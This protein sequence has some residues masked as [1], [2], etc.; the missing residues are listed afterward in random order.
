MMSWKLHNI[1]V[2][3]SFF[4]VREKKKT[5]TLQPH[6]S[7]IKIMKLAGLPVS[8]NTTFE[9]YV[10]KATKPSLSTARACIMLMNGE[11]CQIT[12]FDKQYNPS[13]T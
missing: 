2:S 4:Q 9:L 11:P 8:S 13:V 6:K 3:L 12:W 7:L 10:D 5:V 1:L